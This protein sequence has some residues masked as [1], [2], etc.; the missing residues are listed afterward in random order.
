M[1]T[2]EDFS[3]EID[4]F[5]GVFN[6]V[7][8]KEDCE[9]IIKSFDYQSS[10]GLSFDRGTDPRHKRDDDSMCEQYNTPY[11]PDH[12]I[13]KLNSLMWEKCHPL[14][15][16]Q[17]SVL[18]QADTYT[19]FSYKIQRTH[20]GQ[21]YHIWH[22]EAM[23][24]PYTAR[25]LVYTLYLNDVEEG[26]ETEFLYAN[27]RLKPQAGTFVLFPASFTHTHRGNPPISNTKYMLTGWLE[28]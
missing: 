17:Y 15:T 20:P 19:N 7:L 22:Y 4:N 16:K 21:G 13:E 27:R 18:N 8:S 26:G 3:Y 9:E 1:S 2:Q 25:V 5:I 10:K 23:G 24:R 14:Y 11:I 6:N 12:I 28:H